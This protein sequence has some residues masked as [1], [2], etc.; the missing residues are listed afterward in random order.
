MADIK[1]ACLGLAFKPDIDDLRES[2]AVG[3]AKKIASL[4]CKVHSV[5]P[6]IKELPAKLQGTGI[7]LSALGSAMA[8]ADVVCVLV[9]HRPFIEQV[10]EIRKHAQCIDIVGL[11]AE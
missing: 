10:A 7:E 5:E 8:D 4:G 2:P 3:V 11:F 9:K 6:N 1:V